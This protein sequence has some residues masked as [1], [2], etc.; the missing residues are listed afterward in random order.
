MRRT[1]VALLIGFTISHGAGAQRV[2]GR[3]LDAYTSA[4]VPGAVVWFADSAG[5]PLARAIGDQAGRFSL[6]RTTRATSVHVVRIGYRPTDKQLGGTTADTTLD[7]TMARLPEMLTPLAASTERVCPRDSRGSSGLA[8]WEQARAAL[9]AGLVARESQPPHIRLIAFERTR[10]PVLK[11][12]VNQH[13]AMKDIAVDRSYVA[14]LPAWEFASRGYMREDRGEE[15]VYYAPDNETLL[16]ATFATTH[17]LSVAKGDRDH[18]GQVG[19]A[20][21]P[22]E[23]AER[24]TIVDIRGVL[25]LDRDVP[26]LRSIE[27]TYT[28]IE[29]LASESGGEIVFVSMPN[30]APM[31]NRWVIRT[32]L[33]AADAERSDGPPRTPPP[34]SRRFNMRNVGNREVGGEVASIVWPDG[35]GWHA[36]LPRITGVVQDDNGAPVAGARVWMLNTSDTTVSGADGH[37]A[38]P[39]VVPGA[40][41]VLASDSVLAPAGIPRT[42]NIWV[43]LDRAR[44]AEMIVPL[45]PRA[46]VLQMLCEGQRFQPDGGVVLGQ[47]LDSAGTPRAFAQIDLFRHIQMG[48]AELFRQDPGGRAGGDGRFVICGTSPSEQLRIRA[49]SVSEMGE[50]TVA[51]NADNVVRASIVIRPRR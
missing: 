43:M 26:A 16:D 31:V 47:V 17:C 19:I 48:K 51:R 15:R 32:T 6:M 30:G 36:Q 21:E 33:L 11:R 27:F 23:S 9:L 8:L 28:N 41:V 25:W 50:V 5:T 4:P 45:H 7:L 1:A 40:Y 2:H 13:S 35:T 24:D 18:A 44:D 37:F 42:Q 38:L 39:Y 20:F 29:P 22:S 46:E 3:V 12:M 49:T 10:D 34:R 14:A